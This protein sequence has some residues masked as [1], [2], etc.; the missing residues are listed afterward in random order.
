MRWTR[1]KAWYAIRGEIDGMSL[2]VKGNET[3][4][5]GCIN[6]VW[7]ET[8]TVGI[9]VTIEVSNKAHPMVRK[10]L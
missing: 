9:R 1:P 10:E 2:C 7:F 5:T 3:G 6:K 8:D 4:H